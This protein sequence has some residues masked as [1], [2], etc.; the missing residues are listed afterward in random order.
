MPPT[1]NTI[2]IMEKFKELYGPIENDDMKAALA[3]NIELGFI[4]SKPTHIEGLSILKYNPAKTFFKGYWNPCIV[5]G[6]R[7]HIVDKDFN[8]INMP[9]PKMFNY[10]ELGLMFPDDTIVT[11]YKKRNGFMLDVTWY[12]GQL[13]VATTGT[14]TSDFAKLG[15]AYI[16]PWMVDVFKLHENITFTFEVC[17]PSDPHIIPENSGLYLIAAR[18]SHSWYETYNII[19]NSN[20]F[21]YM[22]KEF[23]CHDPASGI[24]MDRP[25]TGDF[26]TILNMAK[27]STHEGYVTWYKDSD[28]VEYPLKVKSDVYRIKKMVARAKAELISGGI[29]IKKAYDI[30]TE[31]KDFISFI[32]KHKSHIATLP[33]QQRLRFMETY[34][35]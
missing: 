8:P 31:Q 28:G 30:Q 24:T 21:V 32:E 25:T 35:E 19:I 12:E 29:I 33:E 18:Y 10:G 3:R 23:R 34:Y 9:L 14:T 5:Q 16:K 7:G 11:A 20:I 4:K 27:N 2:D 15:A 1:Q 6:A 13:I 26:G 22:Y 17:D